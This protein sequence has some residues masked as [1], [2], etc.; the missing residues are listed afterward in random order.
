[1]N[2]QEGEP[3]LDAAREL[4]ELEGVLL[5]ERRWADWLALYTED[6]VY[7][8]PAWKSDDE[9][10]ADPETEL[11]HIYYVDRAALEDRII[12]VTSSLSPA[13][14][15]LARTTHMLSGLRPR[16]A[17]AA[18][19]ASFH[20]NW[21]THVFWPATHQS[22]TFFGHADYDLRWQEDAW[23]IARKVI[24]LKNDYIPAVIDFYCL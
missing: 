19:A 6:C 2:A 13:S 15:P 10:G 16:G 9:L 8:M 18:G 14:N 11:S 12:R 22:H 4:I 3:A 1:M 20:T 7:W 5:D 23:R 17:A 24:V 21:T